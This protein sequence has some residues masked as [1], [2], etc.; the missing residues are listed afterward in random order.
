MKAAAPRRFPWGTAES[1]LTPAAES[2]LRQAQGRLCGSAAEELACQ[3]T[4]ERATPPKEGE[5]EHRSSRDRTKSRSLVRLGGLVMTR[6]VV[7][8][9][10]RLS[11]KATAGPS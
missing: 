2:S 8:T 9:G 11:V 6:T 10:W 5:M 3:W 1:G 4:D 7:S